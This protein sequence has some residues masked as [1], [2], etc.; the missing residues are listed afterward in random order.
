MRT[1]VNLKKTVL[2]EMPRPIQAPSKVGV[3]DRPKFREGVGTP[4]LD[5]NSVVNVSLNVE[6]D[7]K[8]NFHLPAI[9]QLPISVIT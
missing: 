1:V 9:T 8:G 2:A 6:G 5:L 7:L 3:C 4:F